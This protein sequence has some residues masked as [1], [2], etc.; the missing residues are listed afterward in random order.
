VRYALLTLQCQ[1][2]T[3]LNSLQPG[4]INSWPEFEQAFVRNFSTTYTHPGLPCQ[5]AQ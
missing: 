5:L 4:S 2:R 3:W 1:A